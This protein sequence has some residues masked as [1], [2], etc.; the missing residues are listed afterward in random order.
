VGTAILAVLAGVGIAAWA[1]GPK[2]DDSFVAFRQRDVETIPGT[3]GY[4]LEP[5][6]D[7]L[8]TV[9]P[10][11]VYPELLGAE[12]DRNVWLTLATVRN[13]RDGALWGPAW[14]FVTHHLC[15]FDSKGDFVSPARSGADDGCTPKNMLVQVVDA[16]SGE[17]L[18]AFDAYDVDGGW[19]P[20][21]EGVPGQAPVGTRFH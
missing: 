20:A 18:A 10:E 17:F 14:V 4:L 11:Q 5:V 13:D 16:R 7:F 2:G 15:Y 19:S 9:N 21:R 6:G 1:A 3:F 8:P 12:Q